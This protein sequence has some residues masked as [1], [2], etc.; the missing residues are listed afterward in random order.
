M[1]LDGEMGVGRNEGFYVSEQTEL[2]Y[3]KLGDYNSNWMEIEG[4]LYKSHRVGRISWTRDV[5]QMTQIP[6]LQYYKMAIS[7]N[8]GPIA[9]MLRD[10]TFFIGNSDD[11]KNIVFVFTS[12]GELIQTIC[13]KDHIKDLS[14]NQRW[15][16]FDFTF[17]EDILLLTDTG[18]LFLFDPKS[19][20]MRDNTPV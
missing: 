4:I 2:F 12:Y 15:V 7:R 11:T 16:A 14:D 1:G 17:D 8:G 10:N 3:N 9:F 13:L 20:Q 18:L 5:K 6:N 19:G